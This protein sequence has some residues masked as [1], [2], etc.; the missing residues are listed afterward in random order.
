MGATRR[1]FSCNTSPS[2]EEKARAHRAGLV[3]ASAFGGGCPQ[4]GEHAAAGAACSWGLPTCFVSGSTFS[5]AMTL[6]CFYTFLPGGRYSKAD[7]RQ[8]DSTPLS[9]HGASHA[10]E[11][12]SLLRWDLEYARHET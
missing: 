5:A 4:S 10:Q 7:R 3:L 9:I 11:N 1:K 2:H 12:C 8:R 6:G